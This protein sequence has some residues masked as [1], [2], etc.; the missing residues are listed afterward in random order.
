MLHLDW[1]LLI[2]SLPRLRD[3]H[4]S[5]G[6]PLFGAGHQLSSPSREIVSQ[7]FAMLSKQTAAILYSYS[8]SA[9]IN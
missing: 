9:L 8:P 7:T 6:T 1:Y 2:V 4:V 3:D 5:Y